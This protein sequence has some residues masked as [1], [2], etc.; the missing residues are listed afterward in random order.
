MI[1]ACVKFG[2]SL[3]ERGAIPWLDNLII[4]R[5]EDLNRAE[6]VIDK[7]VAGPCISWEK[8]MFG[9]FFVICTVLFLCVLRHDYRVVV[10]LSCSNR[11][12]NSLVWC[13]CSL[14]LF[15]LSRELLGLGSSYRLASIW[16]SVIFFL[17][18]CIKTFYKSIIKQYKTLQKNRNN[19]QKKYKWKIKHMK[20]CS[21]APMGKCKLKQ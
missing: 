15:L 14:K 21:T 20:R 6:T 1:W 8:G 2:E 3:P 5:W 18:E 13:R 4:Q 11:V 9:H 10:F 16:H 7:A 12:T 19:S 17:V